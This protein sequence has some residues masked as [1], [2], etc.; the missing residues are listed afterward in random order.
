MTQYSF[1]LGFSDNSPSAV[2]SGERDYRDYYP[3][4]LTLV[5]NALSLYDGTPELILDPCA[6]SG[7]WGIT[8]RSRWLDSILVGVDQNFDQHHMDYDLWWNQDFF[9]IV[10]TMLFDLVMMNPPFSL[11]QEFIERGRL[12]LAP[13]GKL[14]ALVKITLLCSVGR[15]TGFW[16]HYRPISVHTLGDRPS[17]SGDGKTGP[18]EE[19]M[20]VVFGK[21][22]AEHTELEIGRLWK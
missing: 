7:N 4:P 19:Y 2:Q 9:S 12:H 22:P 18:G 11:A 16:P 3:T 5:A 14:I 15:A 1:P 13:Q 21:E 6:G 17:F 10:P 20:L 8:A